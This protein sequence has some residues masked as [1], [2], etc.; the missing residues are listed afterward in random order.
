VRSPRRPGPVR[1]A[2]V[3][4]GALGGAA[5]CDGLGSLAHPEVPVWVH[6][7]GGA[8]SVFLRRPLTIEARRT[9]EPY[10]RSRPEIDPLHRR[11]F[12][13]TADGGLYALNA[14][15]GATFWRF[16]TDDAVQS[17]P[18][19]DLR[20]DAVYF[21][22]ND[23]ALYKL[24]AADGKMLWRFASNAEIM[25]RPVLHGGALYAVNANDTL[26]CLEPDTGVLKWFRQR[27]PAYGMEI[28]GYA[29]PTVWGDKVFVAFSDGAVMAYRTSDGAE[30]WRGAVDL[31]ADAE[32][33]RVGEELRYLD[34]DTTPVIVEGAEQTLVVVASYEGGL[35]A[36]DAASGARAWSN[37]APTGVTE[38]VLWQNPA[39]RGDARARRRVLVAS[40]GLT[41]LWGIDPDDGRELWRRELPTGGV[42]GAAPWA[43][44]LLVGTTR[45]GFFL[46]H[47][48]DGGIIDAL[49]SGGAFAAT[50]AAAGLRAYLISNEGLLYGLHIAPPG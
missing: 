30:A 50:P 36:L 46:V 4:L 20:E 12:V 3:A 35:V 13:G 25:R 10:E 41:G 44:A 31:T 39:R 27:T 1:T 7:P 22:S 37:E 23:G 47:P 17:E 15:D 26:V 49:A 21:G 11:I 18:H 43:G 38:L 14:V 33:A 16:Q 9:G 28:S 5:A 48:L 8:L 42:T 2:I 34:V 19:Y 24:R 40:S 29:G 6:H 45:Y 32:Q